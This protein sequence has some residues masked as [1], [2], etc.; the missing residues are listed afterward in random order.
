MS[1]KTI[2]SLVLVLLSSHTESSPYISS[3]LKTFALEDVVPLTV[4]FFPEQLSIQ[5]ISDT[6][7]IY[8]E[9]GLGVWKFD[10]KQET[11]TAILDD[12][13]L[14]KLS[15]Y[16][17]S[18]FSEDQKYLLVTTNKQKKYRHSN[19]AEYW[20]Y[21]LETKSIIRLG[22]KSLDV[23][24]WG[25]GR[26]LAYVREC[27]VYYVH[28]VDTD[29]AVALTRD[30]KP[31]EIYH[32]VT[33]WLY[34]EEMFNAAEAM[35]FSPKGS[36]LAV[37]TFNDT[38]VETATYPYY[39]Q[40][41]DLSNQYPDIVHF[42]YPKAGRQNPVV[43][44]R[45]FKLDDLRGEPWNIPAPVDIVGLDH[46]LGR[47]NWASEQNLVVLWL[48]RRQNISV[49]VNCD[50]E[51]DKCSIVK[52]HSE[53]NGWIDV[54]SPFFDTTGNKMLEIQYLFNGDQRFPHAAKFDFLSLTT[55]D[56]SPGNSTVTEILGWNQAT[57]T[58]YYVVSPGY[59]PWLRQMWATSGG[60]VRCVS[61]REPSCHY[62]TASFSP[63]A[64]FAIVTCS[65][66]YNPPKI[67][68]YNSRQDTFKLIKDNSRLKDKL[69]QYKLPMIL[70]NVVAMGDAP[71]GHVKLLLPPNMKSGVKYPM[72][73][74]VYAGPGT[75]RVKDNFDL[76][77]YN[78]YLTTNRS[79]IVASIDVRGSGVIGV[80]AMHAV[81]NALGT[82]EVTDTLTTI[83]SLASVYSFI[84]PQR[85]GV[86][87]WSYGGFVS[88]MML[89]Q[90][91]QHTLSCGAAV[92][93][94]TSWLY[95]D[96]MYTERYM[97]TPKAN[98]DGYAR[99][100]VIRQAEKL[101][102]RKYLLVHG[103]DDD[104]VHFQHSMLLAKQLQHSDI[105]F[106]QMSYADEKH[107]LLGVSRH[108]Y[109]MLDRFW[110]KCFDH[111]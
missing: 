47:V 50:L 93:P 49:L 107:S 91:D 13:D 65:A 28:D 23:V 29:N 54:R 87:G 80:E 59:V 18:M 64:S 94:V 32:G 73:V 20:V 40:P 51:K 66:S 9:P 83:K 82:V 45:V 56:L 36:Y 62:V 100:D 4:S 48:N 85:I 95:Y 75:S 19:T 108:F 70:F 86:W 104:N 97:D 53:S 63:G 68:L 8:K 10:A 71:L 15:N 76:E 17:I 37:A 30:G 92:A 31:G 7:Y 14:I 46:Y 67:F 5:W 34:E 55:E 39:G 41:S 99:S 78:T 69:R 1:V 106:E 109:H 77:Y 38:N 105:D 22:K 21:D 110:T 98:P 101:R 43:G 6:E 61:C 102:G 12:T 111:E 88:T 33:D 89:I 74:R 25:T 58:V 2:V 26:S 81:N 3:G 42:K 44:L 11:Y 103:T 84:D 16:S 72:V 96:T 24:V 60:V 90:D 35:W 27:N 52:E 57:D 79:Y